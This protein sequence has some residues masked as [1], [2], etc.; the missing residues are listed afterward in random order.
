MVGQW[1][2]KKSE[3]LKTRNNTRILKLRLNITRDE[4]PYEKNFFTISPSTCAAL[5]RN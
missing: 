3:C 2:I 1:I 5:L 4:S